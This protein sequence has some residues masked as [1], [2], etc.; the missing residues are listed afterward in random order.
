MEKELHSIVETSQQYCH[1]L[2]GSHCNFHCDHKSLGF[3]HF[4]SDRVSRWR[5]TLEEFDYSFIYFPSKDNTI[6]DMLSCFPTTSVET[7]NYGEVT[8]TQDSSFP[9]TIYNIKNASYGLRATYHSSLTASPN[10][11]I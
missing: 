5:A 7:S 10:Q 11:T 6:A 9:T 4:K 8:M 3:Q 1:I 2:L